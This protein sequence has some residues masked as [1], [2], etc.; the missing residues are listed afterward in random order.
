M[1]R[2]RLLLTQGNLKLGEGVHTWSIPAIATCPGRS[3]ICEK[4]CYA[5]RHRFRFEQIRRRLDWNLQQSR[6]PDFVDR[7]VD[8][9]RRR[10]V[11]VLRLHVSGDFG[12]EEYA[13]RWLKIM[14]RSQRTKF[15]MYSRSWRVPEIAEVLER[16]AKLRCARVWYSIDDET[17]LPSRVPPGVRLAYLQ[18]T[19]TPPPKNSQ[20]VFRILRLRGLPAAP[21]VCSS[22]TPDGKR[23]G[24]TCGSCAR[25]FQ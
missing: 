8:E 3:S 18:T 17:G 4:V 16:I 25:C 22:E 7:M 14:K 13:A 2:Q 11:L 1:R 10:G 6:R 20:L 24:V 9:L 21:A 23:S 12:S 15:F 5:V 19:D